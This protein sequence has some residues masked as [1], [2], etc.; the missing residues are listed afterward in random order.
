MRK[1]WSGDEISARSLIG[2]PVPIENLRGGE[3]WGSGDCT[4]LGEWGMGG[5]TL[6]HDR[7]PEVR[8]SGWVTRGVAAARAMSILF[9]QVPSTDTQLHYCKRISWLG[10]A[11]TL[12]CCGW[13]YIPYIWGNNCWWQSIHIIYPIKGS[14]LFEINLREHVIYP[15]SGLP[16][17][18]NPTSSLCGIFNHWRAYC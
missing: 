14:I 9:W 5:C 10:S 2:A 1:S 12:V 13:K 18:N 3:P 11:F 6:N 4:L 15:S 17:D 16:E 8:V 7:W